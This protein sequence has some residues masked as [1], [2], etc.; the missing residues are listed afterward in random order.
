MDWISE[1][2]KNT[3]LFFKTSILSLGSTTESLHDVHK[4]LKLL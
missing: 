2:Q 4:V 1:Q 3:G